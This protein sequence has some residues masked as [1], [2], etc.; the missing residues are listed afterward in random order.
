[1]AVPRRTLIEVLEDARRV[2][3]L[4]SAPIARVIEHAMHFVRAV[5]DGSETVIDVGTGA[6]VPGL[7]I[8]LER[9]ELS[10]TMV[11]RRATR[12]DSLSRAVMA[13]GLTDRVTVVT[14]DAEVLGK[15]APYTAGFDV[16][17]SRGLGSPEYTATVTRP[18]LREGGA[19]IVSE[20]PQIDP[21]RWPPE[22]LH[23]RGFDHL[24]HLGQVV[25]LRATGKPQ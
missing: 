1:M 10:V 18:F 20:P 2:G 21:E 4:G 14:G 17:V 16:A 19:L 7:V 25:R 15:T 12:M 11:D 8:A 22:L 23:R 3:S 5:P 24:E 13:L 6:G 9:P